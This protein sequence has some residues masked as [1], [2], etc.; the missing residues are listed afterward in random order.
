[1][2]NKLSSLLLFLSQPS[3]IVM[4]SCSA[5]SGRC[6]V[7]AKIARDS[8][9]LS[10]RRKG[11]SRNLRKRILFWTVLPEHIAQARWKKPLCTCKHCCLCVKCCHLLDFMRR[12]STSSRPHLTMPPRRKL[13]SFDRARAIAWFQDGVTKR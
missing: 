5:V 1:M 13:S 3:Q 6:C 11:K 7:C 12:H 2:H 10:L 8:L 4:E 9:L